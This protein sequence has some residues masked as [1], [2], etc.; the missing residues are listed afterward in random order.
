MT[1]A[2]KKTIAALIGG[3]NKQFNMSE[4]VTDHLISKLKALITDDY[5]LLIT[6]SRRTPDH[7]ISALKSLETAPNVRLHIAGGTDMQP[8]PYPGILGLADTLMVTE[9]S[10]N[11]LMEASLTG[12]PVYTLPLEGSP[13]KFSILHKSLQE[14]GITRPFT[15]L[16]EDWKYQP[17]NE[18]DRVAREL[19]QRWQAR[20][21]A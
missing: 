10:V 14:R 2:A 4:T 15:G 19:V 13:G 12:K 21:F 11:M 17:F 18:T 5:A 1:Y 3:P 6:T 8:N 16:I 9:D 7:M 20:E